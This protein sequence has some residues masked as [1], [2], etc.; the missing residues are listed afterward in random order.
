MDQGRGSQVDRRDKWHI[1]WVIKKQISAY[2][3]G[4]FYFE[5]FFFR[6][7]FELF[8]SG[9]GGSCFVFSLE[10]HYGTEL[11]MAVVFFQ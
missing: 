10:M 7:H 2:P 9:Y 1:Y 8:P 3:I 11:G 6:E 5:L 4:F